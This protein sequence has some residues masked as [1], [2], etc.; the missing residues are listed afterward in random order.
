MIA[1]PHHDPCG[2]DGSGKLDSET[3]AIRCTTKVSFGLTNRPSHS[4]GCGKVFSLCKRCGGRTVVDDAPCSACNPK[5][6]AP[7]L[8]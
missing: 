8:A 3:M 4:Q 6:P 7:K 1:L 2:V 5:V